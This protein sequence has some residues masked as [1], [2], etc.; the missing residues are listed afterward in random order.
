MIH[1]VF[2]TG[3]MGHRGAKVEWMAGLGDRMGHTYTAEVAPA[4]VA[5]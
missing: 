1:G 4:D 5:S 2:G 3:R